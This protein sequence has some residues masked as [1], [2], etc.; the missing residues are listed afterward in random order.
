MAQGSLRSFD[1]DHFFRVGAIIAFLSVP[2]LK[3]I[4][5]SSGKNIWSIFHENACV[6]NTSDRTSLQNIKMSSIFLNDKRLK[7]FPY[8]AWL[9]LSKTL[10]KILINTFI[11]LT[12]SKFFK[13]LITI[14][15]QVFDSTHKLQNDFEQGCLWFILSK[16]NNFYQSFSLS[17][18]PS[19]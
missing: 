3:T 15:M 1:I 18:E 12:P 14:L 9:T 4:R 7:L 11:K 19:K 17:A 13:F 5:S 6:Y 8:K 2:M 10:I 16:G